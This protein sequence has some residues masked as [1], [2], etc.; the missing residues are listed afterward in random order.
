MSLQPLSSGIDSAWK[1]IESLFIER[2]Q[3][4]ILHFILRALMSKTAI[5]NLATELGGGQ[6]VFLFAKILIFAISCRY[7]Y[8]KGVFWPVINRSRKHL[9]FNTFRQAEKWFNAPE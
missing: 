7:D 8:S 2:S 6:V 3:K 5:F 4:R 9:T 1:S